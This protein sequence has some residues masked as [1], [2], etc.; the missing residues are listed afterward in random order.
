MKRST[1]LLSILLAFTCILSG[2]KTKEENKD[3][4]NPDPPVPEHVHIDANNDHICDE[5]LE[6][7]SDHVFS[8]NLHKCDICGEET[9]CA[10]L[11]GDGVCDICHKTWSSSALSLFDAYLMERL[12]Y[13]V[14]DVDFVEKQGDY[15]EAQMSGDARE[16]LISIFTSNGYTDEIGQYLD[17]EAHYLEKQS[18]SS[19]YTKVVV[20]V[21]FNEVNNTTFID[22]S[23][24]L[25]E[26]SDFPITE[27]IKSLHGYTKEDPVFPTDGERFIFE[28]TEVPGYCIVTY[29]GNAKAY[30]DVLENAGYYIDYSM[31]DYYAYPA[32]RCLSS[33]RTVAIQVTDLTSEVQIEFKGEEAPNEIEWSDFVKSCMMSLFGEVMPFAN[34]NFEV[35]NEQQA[36]E[37]IEDHGYF[38]VESYVIDAFKYAVEAFRKDGTF[39]EEYTKDGNYYTFTKAMGYCL[40]KAVISCEFGTTIISFM[41]VF[42]AYD[43]FPIEQI[44][45]CLGGT[46][47][48]VI[49]EADGDSFYLYYEEAHPHIAN[50]TVYGDKEDFE[51]YLNKLKEEGYSTET[52]TDGWIMATGKEETIQMF[53]FDSTSAGS[54][55]KSLYKV[56]IHLFKPE[57]ALPYFPIDAVLEEL[58]DDIEFTCPIPTGET[59]TPSYPYGKIG[60]SDIMITITG[61]DRLA[62]IDA[63]IGAGYLYDSGYSYPGKYDA[64]LN[65]STHIAIY[66]YN[67]E[68]NSNYSVE[69]GALFEI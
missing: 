23:L 20:M 3:P 25:V 28:T 5:C 51:N 49:P 65:H 1:G 11:D 60:A 58:D 36:L 30:L 4:V 45:Y 33:G 62:Y 18:K 42:P 68:S 61:G 59:F 19:K 50:L 7:C 63:V 14:P 22:A 27:V 29:D 15:I 52:L 53:L 55:D 35:T 57:E 43:T 12:P 64:Y 66:I 48:D 38:Q 8:T 21:L 26:Q 69:Y 41:K 17:K 16:K 2:C 54:E 40:K 67:S 31:V 9:E 34:A 24:K 47:K 6:K 32:Y 10:D 44:N 37:N 13:F 46:Y 39:D 56:E